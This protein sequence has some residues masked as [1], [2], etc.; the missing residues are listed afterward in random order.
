ML[1]QFVSEEFM[2][3]RKLKWSLFL[4]LFLG[5]IMIGFQPVDS[6]ASP[7]GN[8]I[9]LVVDG[10]DITAL[11]SPFI[12][13]DRTLVPVRFVT[14]SIGGKVDWD[15]SNRVVTLTKGSKKVTL[16]IDSFL[17][18]Y[19][20]GESF[21][22]SDVAPVIINDR[23][24]V[25]VRLVSNALGLFVDWD[26]DTR[27][28]IIDSSKTVKPVKFHDLAITSITPEQVIT[29]KTTIKFNADEKYKN[30]VANTRLLLIDPDKRSGFVV[31]T[32]PGFVQELTYLPDIEEKGRHLLVV[33]M[34]NNQDQLIAG[35]LVPIR[36]NLQP[37]MSI[38]GIKNFEIYTNRVTFEP[39][40]NVIPAHI[41]YELTRLDNNRVTTV[42]EQDPFGSY[43]WQPGRESQGNYQV[44]LIAYDYEGNAYRSEP[45]HFTMTVDGF[46]TLR[47]VTE[48]MRVDR[49][50]S[51]LANRN[52]DV[53]E[54]IF[55]IRDNATGV[56]NDL[57]I[58]P[59]GNYVFAPNESMSGNK[60]LRVSV[61]DVFG[62]LHHS[63][64]VNVTIDGSPN[65]RLFGVGPNQVVTQDINLRVDSNVDLEQVNYRIKNLD[66]GTTRI[67]TATDQPAT[68]TPLA[69]DGNNV[70]V[71][72]EAIY[73]G[74]KI[75]S[76]EIA[77]KTYLGELFGPQPI[78]PRNE[79]LEFASKMALKSFEKTGMSAALQTSQAILET[80]WGQSIPVDKYTGKFSNNLFGIKGT[81]S[82]GSVI[83]NTWEVYNGVV[84][85][86]DD[87][88]R[89]Y[90]QVQESWDD[91][92][93]I[94]LRLPRYEPF[95]EVMHHSSLGAWAVRR[96]G[97]A[98]D[99][100]YP[101]KLIRIIRQY[102]LKELD[103]VTI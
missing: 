59:Y 84:Y 100:Q 71:V 80:G 98:T 92:K 86:I 101:L 47:G 24:Y 81:A 73:K 36:L 9:R 60:A 85:R 63:P 23:T 64:W 35:D 48:G 67:I 76:Q 57:A 34:Y 46:L 45:Y 77:F 61:R 83:S 15:G 62:R 88:F 33:A 75:T 5:L 37:Q 22:L 79:F 66:T 87:H 97:Y 27:T 2:M 53:T 14:E 55:S 1:G 90:H 21:E 89:A 20:D 4:L 32:K 95:R 72:A 94:L 13:N 11:S 68:F 50:V 54:T 56:E 26:H 78:V 69:T 17:V 102:N 93:D 49:P 30:Q 96:A 25:P 7:S 65:I 28:V 39:K 3:V 52:F 44:V 82:N 10:V 91:H 70:S 38:G 6:M 40:V 8:S 99:P 58:I 31:D 103:R 42:K 41:E 74:S 19:N 16:Q 29:G 51:L 12:R 18:S 43:S